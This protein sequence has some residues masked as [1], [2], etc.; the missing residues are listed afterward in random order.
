MN[1]KYSNNFNTLKTKISLAIFIISLF[2]I[3]FLLSYFVSDYLT[4]PKYRVENDNYNN[5]TVYN[6][7]SNYLDD[8]IFVTLKTIDN[9]DFSESLSKLKNVMNLE[10]NLTLDSLSEELSKVGYKLS[11]WNEAKLIYVRSEEVNS[12][13]LEPNKYY[14]GAEEGYISIFKTDENGKVIE[15]EKKVYT[16]Y[17]PLSDLPEIDQEAIKNN[18]FFFDTKDEALIK[19]SEMVS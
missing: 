2:I 10:G 18:E 9:I 13:S 17:K 3:C 19:L 4:N 16:E 5:K 14:L 1:N 12:T 8:N 6:E 11:D 15:E 7:T